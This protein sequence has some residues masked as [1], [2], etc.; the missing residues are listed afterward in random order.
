MRKAVMAIVLLLGV[1]GVAMVAVPG[2]AWAQ[3]RQFTGKVDKVD[4]KQIIVDNR[5]GDKVPFN[6][7]EETVVEGTKTTWD[8]V[9]KDDWVTVDWK[10]VDK[11]RKAYKVQVL[12]PRNEA[13]ED[14]G[15]VPSESGGDE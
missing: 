7:V 13:G 10:F 5:K 2:D 1:V 11:P 14:A 8:A 15:E 9:K 12:P 3:Y 6:K 4:D